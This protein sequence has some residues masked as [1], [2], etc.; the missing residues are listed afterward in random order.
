MTQSEKGTYEALLAEKTAFT[1]R[2]A[3]TF[4]LRE[5][6]ALLLSTGLRPSDLAL[7]LDVHPRTV[8]AWMESEDRDL[9]RQRDGILALKAL[10]LYLLRRGGLMP[11]QV[12][13][14]L[15]EPL[16]ELGFRRPLAVLPEGGLEDVVRASR[17]FTRPEPPP[18]GAPPDTR[19]VAAG[20]A[21]RDRQGP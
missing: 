2:L 13:L 10:M 15:V 6:V 8:R 14:W 1:D 7:A 3:E 17:S 9:G 16:P 21:G 12:A 19:A 20:A 4:D 5:T 11:N 18:G